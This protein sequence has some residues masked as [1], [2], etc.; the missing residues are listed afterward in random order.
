MII[1]NKVKCSRLSKLLKDTPCNKL[2]CATI[3]YFYYA[4]INPPPSPK[5]TSALLISKILIIFPYLRYYIW[6]QFCFILFLDYLDEHLSYILMNRVS[7]KLQKQ[8]NH[9]FFNTTILKKKKLLLTYVL[10]VAEIFCVCVM[11]WGFMCL[12]K[13]SYIDF[14]IVKI[15]SV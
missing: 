13:V 3:C 4:Q 11:Q 7:F 2:N 8:V 1:N 15:Y 9:D 14:R 5:K 6:S 12:L 10:V